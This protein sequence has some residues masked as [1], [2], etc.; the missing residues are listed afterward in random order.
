MFSRYLSLASHL[1]KEI[2]GEV[3][4]DCWYLD[5]VMEAKEMEGLGETVLQLTLQIVLL[6]QVWWIC[7]KS[8]LA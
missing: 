7:Y 5:R 8:I 3:N 1:L 4:Y 6:F 2:R